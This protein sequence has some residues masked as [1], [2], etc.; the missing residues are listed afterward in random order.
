V[1]EAL[2]VAEVIGAAEVIAEEE[3]TSAR[4]VTTP[5]AAKKTNAS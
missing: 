3:E 5:E 1:V 4:G 2:G